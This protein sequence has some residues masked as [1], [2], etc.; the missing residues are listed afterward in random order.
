MQILK[1]QKELENQKEIIKLKEV[2]VC[3]SMCV[4]GEEGKAYST[5]LIK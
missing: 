1:E 5:S 4:C 3:V 2:F